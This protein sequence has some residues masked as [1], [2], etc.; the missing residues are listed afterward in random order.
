[1]VYCAKAMASSFRS[2]PRGFSRLLLLRA[3]RFGQ[4]ASYSTD[5]IPSGPGS[6]ERLPGRPSRRRCFSGLLPEFTGNQRYPFTL[7][8]DGHWYPRKSLF[9]S[10]LVVPFYLPPVLCGVPT[11]NVAF[12]LAWSQ[13]GGGGPRWYGHGP[14][15]SGYSPT[16][17]ARTGAGSLPRP[18]LWHRHLDGGGPE[19]QRPCGSFSM[20]R[21]SDPAAEPLSAFAPKS[22]SGRPPGRCRGLYPTSDR[23]PAVSPGSVP[24]PPRSIGGLE[25]L[26]Q[27]LHWA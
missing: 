7:G 3:F 17:G 8:T 25:S 20:H 13:A 2:A 6:R 10:L 21:R 4:L 26:C 12:W 16:G 18:G 22:R 11:E 23:H 27:A 1:M 19:S 15:L 9:A 24:L 14:L 5:V